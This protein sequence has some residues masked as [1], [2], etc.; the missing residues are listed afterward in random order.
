MPES[1]TAYQASPTGWAFHND[2]AFIR[3]L[4]GPIGSGKS[5]ACC[6]EL[7]RLAHEQQ[8]SPKDGYRYSRWA[9]IRNTYR[10]LLDTTIKTWFDWFPKELGVWRAQDMEFHLQVGDLRTEFLFR[11][12]DRPDDIRKLLSL[13][14]TGGWINEARE[15]PRAVLD[16]LQGRVGRYPSMRD[17][18]GPTRNCIIMDTNPPDEDHWW[19]RLFEEE[20]PEDW[21]IHRQPSGLAPDAENLANLPGGRKYYD[22]LLAGH[23]QAWIDV[24]VHGKY[25][26]VKDGKPV[27]PEFNAAVHT[28]AEHPALIIPKRGE[29]PTIFVGMDFGLTPAAAFA[30]QAPDG[31]YQFLT[32][33][34]TEDMGAAKFG[35]VVAQHIR[36]EYPHCQF[37]IWGDPAGEDR[38]QADEKTPFMVLNAQG[39]KA[40][41]APTNDP[42]LRQGAMSEGLTTLTMTGRPRVVFSPRCRILRKA[43]GGGYK[44]RRLQVAG[45]ERYLDKPDKNM[46][47]HIAE[48]AQYLLVGAG[49]ART[50]I[51]PAVNASQFKAKPTVG[52][53]RRRAYGS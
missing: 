41:P 2:P 12:L 39:I 11:A 49:E 45:D 24:Y 52:R 23:D 44:F 29:A 36:E 8:P 13:E 43:L 19:Y 7:M 18:Q 6:V 9:I 50:L 21:S 33:V 34:V 32:E 48:A 37:K 26:Y 46:Y 27:H 30:Q 25:G 17:G 4:M 3:G 1:H 42:I 16:M 10:E 51:R 5:V 38:S 31:Q 53:R 20:M 15:V 22:R 35:K 47:S 40:I 28:L 14:L